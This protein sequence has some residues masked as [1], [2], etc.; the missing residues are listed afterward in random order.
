VNV[1]IVLLFSKEIYPFVLKH[2]NKTFAS[3]TIQSAYYIVY[4]S[5]VTQSFLCRDGLCVCFEIEACLLFDVVLQVFF[6]LP[7]ILIFGRC[8]T[9]P[10]DRVLMCLTSSMVKSSIYV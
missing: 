3:A 10:L 7:L 8:F 9:R 1:Y 5:H 2:V 6:C 4:D